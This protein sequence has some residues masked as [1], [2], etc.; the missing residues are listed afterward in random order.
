MVLQCTL[1]IV[2]GS[3]ST[4]GCLACDVSFRVLLQALPLIALCERNVTVDS[5][6]F[7]RTTARNTAAFFHALRTALA[8]P[9]AQ[10]K[11]SG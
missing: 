7:L 3:V 4:T 1:Y 5:V 6:V 9:P 2:Y 11:I 10:Q 8:S